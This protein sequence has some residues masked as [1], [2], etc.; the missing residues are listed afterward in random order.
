MFFQIV[1][2][3]ATFPYLVI[4]LLIIRGVTLPGSE[5]GID[6][7]I[8]PDW[9]LLKSPEVSYLHFYDLNFLMSKLN[10][11]HSIVIHYRSPSHI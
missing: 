4:I 8:R 3:T 7:F 10:S 2:F 5:D 9:E 11:S 6:F 1:Y